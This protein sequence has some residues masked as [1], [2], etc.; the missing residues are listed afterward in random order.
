VIASRVSW[1][2]VYTATPTAGEPAEGKEVEH[3]AKDWKGEDHEVDYED[4]YPRMPLVELDEPNVVPDSITVTLKDSGREFDLDDYTDEEEEY[5]FYQTWPTPLKYECW[6]H[7]KQG[8][9]FDRCRLFFN[10]VWEGEEIDV[11]YEYYLKDAEIICPV[12]FSGD[13]YFNEAGQRHRWLKKVGD[14]FESTYSPRV[15]DRGLVCACAGGDRAWA[16]G[17]PSDLLVQFAKEWS[18]YV[19]EVDAGGKR[20]WNVVADLA[21]AGDMYC[22]N[23][24]GTLYIARRDTATKTGTFP[25][26][27]KITRKDLPPYEKVVFSYANGKVELGSGKPVMSLSCDYVYDKGHAE[28][29]CSAAYGFY[30][31]KRRQF[32]VECAGVIEQVG[33]CEEKE[34][35]YYGVKYAG[36]VTGRNFNAQGTTTFT[37]VEKVVAAR[38]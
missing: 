7:R 5:N 18:G 13:L 3:D 16:I 36:L 28:I 14:A 10:P 19:H 4:D 37:L 30:T 27:L 32:T 29:L 2:V 22:F 24:M 23:R 11:V 9:D 31:I 1:D 33:L 26:I 20:I 12:V 6:V 34:L 15:G 38:D 21:R 17:E 35:E 8:D 25:N